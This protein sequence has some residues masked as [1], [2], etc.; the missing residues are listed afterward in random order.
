L[1]PKLV[2]DDSLDVFGDSFADADLENISF[3]EP[4][5]NGISVNKSCPKT[6]LFEACSEELVLEAVIFLHSLK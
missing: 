5:K 6:P 2:A 4:A 3:V 1:N